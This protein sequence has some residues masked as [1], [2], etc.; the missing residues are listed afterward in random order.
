MDNE[1]YNFAC[2]VCG[3][4]QGDLPWGQDGQTP[5]FEIC[6]CCGVT[7]GY[8]DCTVEYVKR[9]REEW[10]GKGGQWFNPSEKPANWS[11]NEQVKSIPKEY[12]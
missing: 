3:N 4:V 9:S 1:A 10:L 2:R 7:F 12:I 6:G 8:E 11:L 5:T